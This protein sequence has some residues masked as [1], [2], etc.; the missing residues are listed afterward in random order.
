MNLESMVRDWDGETIVTRYDRPTG[1]WIFIGIHSTQRG[2]AC[3]GTRMKSYPDVESA[4]QDALKLASGMTYKFAAA[5]FEMGG[6]KAVIA[7]PAD[8]KQRE[9]PDLLRRYGALIH[10]LGGLY[11]T[12]PDVGASSAD[13]DV[14]AETG[15]P[16]VFA[17]T[18]QAGG[19]GDSGPSTLRSRS[20]D[21]VSEQ[22]TRRL[23]RSDFRPRQNRI[24]A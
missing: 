11:Y 7:L 12:G 17:R 5:D 22:R 20:I 9:R 19:S 16:Y 13:M 1:A 6:G 23:G 2:P 8:F 15:A 21:A 4:L 24:W 3:G 14:I 18:P 10:Q